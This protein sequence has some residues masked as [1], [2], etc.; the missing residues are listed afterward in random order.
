[1]DS[2]VQLLMTTLLFLLALALV[3][4]RI[5]N[6]YQRLVRQLVTGLIGLNLL[7]AGTLV[8]GYV[9]HGG[10]PLQY[11]LVQWSKDGI[12]IG[13]YYD[14]ATSLMLVLVSFIGLIVS[15]FSIR[16]LDGEA[17]Q[18]RYFRWLAFTVAAVSLLVVSG[19]LLM[20]MA[21]WVMTSFGLHQLLIHY[22]HRPAARRAAWTKFIISRLGDAFLVAALVLTMKSFGTLELSELFAM[23]KSLSPEDVTVGHAAIGWLLMLGAVTK[24]AQF[25][26]H[27]WLPDT[28][29]TPTPV[30]A[31]MHAGI[32]NA[33]GYLVIR[34]SPLVA[35]AP[36]ALI[37]LA[38]IGAFTACFAG[39]VMMTQPSIKRSLA[40][41]TIAQMGFMMLQCGI[42]AFSAAM[43]HIVAHSLYKAHAFLS[44]GSVLA[45]SQSV[46]GVQ[47]AAQSPRE[48]IVHFLAAGFAALLA[49]AVI[50]AGFGFDVTHKPGGLVLAFILCLALT[51]WGWRMFSRQEPTTVSVA[52]AGIAALCFAYV[53]SYVAVDSLVGSAA[54][55]FQFPATAQFILFDI[56]LA[57]VALFILHISVFGPTRPTW[58]EPLRVHVTNGFYLDAIYRRAFASLAKS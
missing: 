54:A 42:G 38:T 48:S 24:S 31:L 23:A 19:N 44:S 50:S 29:E 3:P 46:R 2:I 49:Y 4:S 25:P 28:M 32:V 7:A 33:G 39:A 40:Y 56:A 12:G 17:T 36:S 9:I 58:L 21:A 14:G 30:S 16:Y 6:A 53:G 13:I 27:T 55:D 1:M 8:V 22:G 5:G 52:V 11:S 47:T 15:R 20:F 18:G 35:L 26:F 10:A 43:L 37:T 41:S 34:M 57:F 51:T 45:Q